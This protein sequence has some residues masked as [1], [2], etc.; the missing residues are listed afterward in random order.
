MSTVQSIVTKCCYILNIVGKGIINDNIM[1][2][3]SE[4]LCLWLFASVTRRLLG[5]LELASAFLLDAIHLYTMLHCS[6]HR[7]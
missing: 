7:T 4:Y 2:N 5:L 6:F 1:S 3:N